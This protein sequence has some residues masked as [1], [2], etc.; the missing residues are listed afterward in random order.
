MAN[1]RTPKDRFHAVIPAGGVGSRLWPLSRASAPKFLHDLTGSGQTLLQDTWDRVTPLATE[2]RTMV[3]TGIAHE[4]AVKEQLANL[5]T[6]N[7]VLEISPKDSTAAI[8]LAAAI[9]ARREPDVIIGSFAAD[10]V[11]TDSAAF[12][13][14]VEEAIAVAATDQIVVIGIEPTEPSVGFGYI[15]TGEELEI[16]AA[17]SAR[18][19]VKFVEKPKI[20]RARK[21]YRSGK[22]LWNA[23]M[24]IAP[25]SLLLKQLKKS[26]PQLHA[27]ILELAAA[28]DTAKRQATIKQIWPSLKKVAIDYS[29][30]EPAASAGLVSVI[31][32]SFSWHDVGDFAA[33]AELQSQGRKNNLAVL[34]SARVLAD[35]ASGILVSDTE[36]MV[37]IIG[38]E[39]IIVVDTPDALLVTN[40][41]N[42][43][44]VKALVDS[45]KATGHNEIL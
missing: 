13:K 39:D 44:K 31:P 38:L 36:R 35:S 25:A 26:E 14:A 10:H 43:Q 24:F 28:W 40:K 42:A 20:E 21:Y 34:G 1:P 33:I 7:L 8:A 37:A 45:L 11:I 41:E 2:A 6:N 29:I 32:A 4:Q 9:L 3:V 17:P 12:Q 18:K 5:P 15:K 19:V 22:Y 30:A 16:S 23:G 27:A